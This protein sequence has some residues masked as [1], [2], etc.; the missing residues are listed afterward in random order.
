MVQGRVECKKQ[1]EYQQEFSNLIIKK[2]PFIPS[3]EEKRF[4]V[5]CYIKNINALLLLAL[6]YF[7]RVSSDGEE[8]TLTGK[9]SLLAYVS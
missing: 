1:Q 8:L 6:I 7:H 5:S 4:H 2:F 9:I 3:M